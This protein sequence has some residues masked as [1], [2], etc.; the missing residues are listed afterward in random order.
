ADKTVPRCWRSDRRTL[1]R[2]RSRGGRAPP[3]FGHA[4]LFEPIKSGISKSSLEAPHRYI[5]CAQW[6]TKTEIPM[7]PNCETLQMPLDG[8]SGSSRPGCGMA[9]RLLMLIKHHNRFCKWART[10]EQ[11][12]R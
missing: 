10:K 9:V 2:C 5:V 7:Y 11:R 12:R 1:N 3:W 4:T 6:G 8:V